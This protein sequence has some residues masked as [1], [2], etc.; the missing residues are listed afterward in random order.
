[1]R[2]LLV[3]LT[4]FLL[5]NSLVKAE[6]LS[7]S[8]GYAECTKIPLLVLVYADWANGANETLQL[9]KSI[10]VEFGDK[11]NYTEL[12]IASNDAK[13]FN[14]KFHIYPKLPYILMYRDGGKVSRYIPR[15]C[16]SNYAC[17]SSKIKSFN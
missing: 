6:V 12:N 2:N 3:L 7:F 1:M 17:I 13:A 15:E 10:Q 4:A 14:D 5:T 11:Y 8:T 16:A 9:F